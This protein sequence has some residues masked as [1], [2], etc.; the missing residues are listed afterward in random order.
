MKNEKKSGFDFWND[1]SASFLEMAFGA[2]RRGSL[3]NPDG[4]GK[5]TGDCGDT[6][7]FFLAVKEGKIEDVAFDI[8]G[9]LNTHACANTI[10]GLCLEKTVEVAWS[11]TP[12]TVIDYLET[13]PADHLHC[14]ELAVGA[15]YLALSDYR[16]RIAEK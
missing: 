1:H 7:A 9:C 14:A 4:Y 10:A 2:D 11:I 12:E 5:K 15:F 6:V 16:R 13:L 3:D 8:N